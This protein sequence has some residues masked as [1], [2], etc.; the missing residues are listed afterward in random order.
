MDQRSKQRRVNEGGQ[1]QEAKEQNVYQSSNQTYHNL[2]S[3]DR[4]LIKSYLGFIDTIGLHSKSKTID[5][6][7]PFVKQALYPSELSQA[8]I[9][10]EEKPFDLAKYIDSP[11]NTPRIF[12]Q[13]DFRQACEMFTEAA[14][15]EPRQQAGIIRSFQ[16]RKKKKKN[17][18]H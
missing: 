2:T 9:A 8:Q 3:N 15:F 11:K 16:V 1:N 12:E 6:A 17:L 13:E 4:I 10:L 18:N 7:S 5:Q 14:Q